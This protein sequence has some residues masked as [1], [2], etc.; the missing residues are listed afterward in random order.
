MTA[1]PQP[2]G[3]LSA[4]RRA[5][6][7]HQGYYPSRTV[8]VPGPGQRGRR[9]DAAGIGRIADGGRTPAGS[10]QCDVW[11]KRWAVP[12][13]PDSRRGG[14]PP[15]AGRIL[16]RA[17]RARAG[18]PSPL[19]G[20]GLR[21]LLGRFGGG[22]LRGG[23]LALPRRTQRECGAH[24]Y[25]LMWPAGPPPGATC[26]QCRDPALKP[27]ASPPAP[28]GTRRPVPARC[29]CRP[30]T[31]PPQRKKHPRRRRL[32]RPATE[33]RWWAAP[34]KRRGAAPAAQRPTDV[35]MQRA[36]SRL[37]PLLPPPLS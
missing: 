30:Q 6:W 4:G 19:S 8:W 17:A 10:R 13:S 35:W 22:A 24:T 21:R 28:R 2:Q 37:N 5:H 25:G 12:L 18:P 16:S 14:R 34:R 3:G 20:T 15:H 23:S 26:R 9:G 31:H 32:A 1:L 29:R 36:I 33:G 11:I 27:P 7:Y